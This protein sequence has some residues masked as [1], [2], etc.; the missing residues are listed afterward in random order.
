MGTITWVEG[1][2]RPKKSIGK[3]L[4]VWKSTFGD[5]TKEGWEMRIKQG[6]R[7]TL[8]HMKES[9]GTSTSADE[10]KHVWER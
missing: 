4:Y 7:K 8:I 2:R 9:T 3:S 1:E 6:Y 5:E 10:T